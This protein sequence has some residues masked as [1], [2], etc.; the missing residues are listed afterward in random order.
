MSG[1]GPAYDAICLR[2]CYAMSGT[3]LE[4]GPTGH[5]REIALQLL[6][7]LSPPGTALPPP[8]CR[9]GRCDILYWCRTVLRNVRYCHTVT[10]AV[11]GTGIGPPYT[12]SG[13]D[14]AYGA[15]GEKRVLRELDAC[16]RGVDA[17]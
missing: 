13:T 17:S 7:E 15:T 9:K 11:S 1:T 3:N 4:Y 8:P 5:V 6:V 14:I 2:A 10:Y 12:K 16:T